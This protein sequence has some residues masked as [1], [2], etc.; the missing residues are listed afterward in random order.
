MT[1]EVWTIIGVLV[2]ALS[3]VTTIAWRGSSALVAVRI[4]LVELRTELRSL[5]QHAPP[6]CHDARRECHLDC[7]AR[8]PTGVRASPVLSR[9]GP[10]TR[11]GA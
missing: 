1:A 11:G 5:M 2:A 6:W 10:D 4:E 8:E 7:P 9:R 3:V